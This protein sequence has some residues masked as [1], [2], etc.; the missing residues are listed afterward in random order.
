MKCG[1]SLLDEQSSIV[2]FSPPQAVLASKGM[3]KQRYRVLFT[4][5]QGGMGTVYLGRDMQLGSRLVAIK[6]MSQSFLSSE[7]RVQAA[8]NFKREAHILAGLQHP[9]LPSIYDHFEENQRW[10]LVMSYIKGQTLEE[11]LSSQGGK[12]PLGEVIEIGIALCNVLHYLHTHHPP[13]IFRDLKPSNI[14]RASDGHIYLIDF[15]IARFFKRGQSKDTTDQGSPGYAAP[16]QYGER[17]TRPSADIYSLGVILYQLISGFDITLPTFHFPALDTLVPGVPLALKALIMQMMDLD[18]KKRPQSME[19]VK[20]RLQS[21]LG[22]LNTPISLSSSPGQ[23]GIMPMVVPAVHK[24]T[25]R[26]LLATAVAIGIALMLLLVYVLLLNVN[27]FNSST[28]VASPRINASTATTIVVNANTPLGVVTLFCRAMNSTAPDFQTAYDQ[29]SRGYQSKHPFTDFQKYFQG[30]SRCAVASVPDARHQAG[31]N[32]TL[33]CPHFDG[34]PPD[35]D[36][37][38]PPPFPP[39]GG[40]P[41]DE[42]QNKPA[43][44]T[45]ISEGGNGWKIDTIYVVDYNCLPPPPWTPPAR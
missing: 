1:R 29:L 31:L 34:P 15:G 30:T 8:Q 21:I 35:G 9:H 32:L 10:Y 17:Q 19:E 38:Q 6:E 39:P 3:L 28:R 12:L 33:T 23:Q 22:K 41:P 16:E 40:H 25:K 45:L 2:P 4:I 36:H 27:A 7:E 43:N 11:Y 24:K 26:G 18:E 14:M 13:I 20:F 44:V 42:P 37:N 5:G